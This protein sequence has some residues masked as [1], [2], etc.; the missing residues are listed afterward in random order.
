[1]RT[2]TKL[3]SI[4]VIFV[5]LASTFNPVLAKRSTEV[6]DE[7]DDDE[8]VGVEE[9][10][11]KTA[12]PSE[13]VKP[14]IPVNDVFQNES[15]GPSNYY[16]EIGILSFVVI[17]IMY[18]FIGKNQNE[19]Y[20][21]AW[22]K[23]YRATLEEQFA[24]V[25][26]AANT[27][28]VKESQARFVSHCTGRANC[29]GAQFTL[30]MHKRHDLLSGLYSIISRSQD[31]V[32]VDIPMNEEAM[33]PFVFALVPKNEKR[34]YQKEFSDLE[35]LATPVNHEAVPKGKVLLSDS[36][37]MVS[38]IL[39]GD[40]AKTL[41]S[42]D[43]DIIFVHFTDQFSV[44]PKYKKILRFVLRM[45]PLSDMGKHITVFKMIFFLVDLIGRTKLSDRAKQAAT[46]KR[47]KIV[48]KSLKETRQQREEAAQQRRLEKER[49]E[50]EKLEK[51]MESM[52]PEQQKKLEAKLKRRE[53]KKGK[54]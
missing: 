11:Q 8:F 49:A 14:E 1:M 6:E 53:V 16:M 10:K 17:Y 30:K 23:T 22:A 20:A 25:G 41:Q 44:D 12:K 48:Q 13:P 47:Q 5:V 7:Y 4:F 3:L 51:R 40:V 39:T 27:L 2:T 26:E 38:T 36:S 52:T 34:Q 21:L 54:I 18:S 29:I 46:Q 24:K 19:A 50:K 33:E 28:L 37:E 31:E 9:V 35:S 42:F 15:K 43:K 45:P 32:I